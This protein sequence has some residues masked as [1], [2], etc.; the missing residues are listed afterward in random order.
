MKALSTRRK[1][2]KY[3][4]NS[5]EILLTALHNHNTPHLTSLALVQNAKVETVTKQQSDTSLSW[6]KLLSPYPSSERNR[7]SS[8]V[9]R[10]VRDTISRHIIPLPDQSR[11]LQSPPDMFRDEQSL[12]Y[13]ANR[14][15]TGIICNICTGLLWRR[16]RILH[17]NYSQ[18][19][20]C[21]KHPSGPELCVPLQLYNIWYCGDIVT[22][23]LNIE[24][25]LTKTSLGKL[26]FHVVDKYKWF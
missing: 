13:P 24:I 18:M 21:G 11:P 20:L 2:S 12:R 26:K 25:W 14:W 9:T 4:C 17:P 1:P 16:R 15:N 23:S 7:L 8:R 19:I 6:M 5:R 3:W 10:D 22:R